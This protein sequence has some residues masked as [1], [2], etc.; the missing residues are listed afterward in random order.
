MSFLRFK[1][2]LQKN[3]NRLIPKWC[4]NRGL[5]HIVCRTTKAL[6]D[7]DLC[8]VHRH[9]RL[10]VFNGFV[11]FSAFKQW[12]DAAIAMIKNV[13]T[14]PSE[15]LAEHPKIRILFRSSESNVECM[16]LNWFQIELIMPT[17]RQVT[18]QRIIDD[19]SHLKCSLQWFEIC[20]KNDLTTNNMFAT[21]WIILLTSPERSRIRN[22]DHHKNVHHI[23]PI[24][25]ANCLPQT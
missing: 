21:I 7:A 11:P 1:N 5:K 4:T 22:D 19:V 18:L 24:L 12:L 25:H 13:V 6:T 8:F 15:C 3:G 23:K 14:L 10:D 17:M 9:P 20:P 16:Q 2:T